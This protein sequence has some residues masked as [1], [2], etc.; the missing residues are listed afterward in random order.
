MTEYG[1]IHTDGSRSGGQPVQSDAERVAR[2]LA[3][4]DG[5]E[6]CSDATYALSSYGHKAQAALSAL[7]QPTQSSVAAAGPD[8]IGGGGG[9]PCGVV[10][11]ATQSDADLLEEMRFTY[12]TVC[13]EGYNDTDYTEDLDFEIEARGWEAAFAV[14]VAKLRQP[15][16]SDALAAE[17]ERLKNKLSVETE[18]S[19]YCPIC[20]SCGDEGCCGSKRCMYPASEWQSGYDAGIEAAINAL[21]ADAK[22]CD[23]FAY[24]ENECACGSWADYKMITSARAVEIVRNLTNLQR[25]SPERI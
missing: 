3:Q 2:A 10:G 22:K 11:V 6:I 4:A 1:R 20:G 16:Q 13:S 19:P 17:I 5:I 23:C 12:E 21:E 25:P 7:R 9:L 24:E 14:A 15:T 8:R 18:P